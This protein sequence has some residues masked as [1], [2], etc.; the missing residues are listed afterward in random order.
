MILSKRTRY[1]VVAL[2][3][4]AK[5]YGKGPVQIS[6]IASEEKIPQR[7]LENILLDLRKIGVLGSQLGKSGGY[8]LLKSPSEVSL[9]D[10]VNHFEGT[11]SLLY[12][13]SE[14][15]YRPCEFCKDESTCGI[16]AVFK[17]LRDSTHEILK[18]T[19]LKTLIGGQG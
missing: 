4:L 7:F 15:S 10:I 5:E 19:T 2:T 18:R 12:C 14:R 3:M 1:A 9:E 6:R 11:L 17:E 13:V 8:Y 16:K